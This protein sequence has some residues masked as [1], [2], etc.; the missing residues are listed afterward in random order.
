MWQHIRQRRAK[1]QYENTVGGVETVREGANLM[2]A[3]CARHSPDHEHRQHVE[4]VHS[5]YPL[6]RNPRWR[7]KT[8]W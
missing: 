1:L 5:G 2:K 7:R 8:K 4:I 6:S 3:V